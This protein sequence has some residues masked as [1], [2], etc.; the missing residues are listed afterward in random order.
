MR[1]G[2]EGRMGNNGGNKRWERKKGT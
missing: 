1:K 2:I